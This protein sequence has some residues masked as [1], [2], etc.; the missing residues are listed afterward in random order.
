MTTTPSEPVVLPDE[1]LY[2][3]HVTDAATA[4]R[5]FNMVPAGQVTVIPLDMTDAQM[6]QIK[7][8]QAYGGED[9]VLRAWVSDQPLG[10]SM[11]TEQPDFIALSRF[12]GRPVVLYSVTQTPPDGVIGVPVI[13]QR[14]YLNIQNVA[15][16]PSAFSFSITILA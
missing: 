16:T 15:N 7:I 13:N 14:Y 8:T 6:V 5:T 3:T 10:A 1:P 2:P 4:A 12:P 9:F 11:L